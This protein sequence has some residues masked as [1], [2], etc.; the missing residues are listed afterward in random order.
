MG[1]TLEKCCGGERKEQRLATKTSCEEDQ[2]SIFGFL[3]DP[4][5]DR[6]PVVS[7][8]SYVMGGRDRTTYL[9]PL[10]AS[11]RG[12]IIAADLVWHGEARKLAYV[13]GQQKS[14]TPYENS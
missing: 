1:T 8:D 2:K 14:S 13:R 10:R 6:G 4:R 9:D 5:L 3:L 7:D 11:K 12:H